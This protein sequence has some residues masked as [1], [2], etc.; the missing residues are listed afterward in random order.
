[1][2]MHKKLTVTNL[3]LLF[4]T[5]LLMAQSKYTVSGTVKQ[6]TSGETLIGVTVVVAEKPNVGVITNE[7]G[8]F[9]TPAGRFRS[10]S[11]K[12]QYFHR[13]F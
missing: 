5:T 4:S 9:N 11:G 6:K 7:Y 2:T 3:L 1:M 10:L 13:L 12:L 8:F